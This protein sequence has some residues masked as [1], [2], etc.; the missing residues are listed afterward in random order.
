MKKIVNWIKKNT[1]LF[2]VLILYF[3][4]WLFY[5]DKKNIKMDQKEYWIIYGV[6][7]Y[8]GVIGFYYGYFYKTFNG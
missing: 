1:G 6:I 4:L 2:I 8:F 3:G 7:T 5:F